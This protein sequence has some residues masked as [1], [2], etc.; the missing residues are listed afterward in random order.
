[1]NLLKN[2]LLITYLLPPHVS[3][4]KDQSFSRYHLVV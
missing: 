1:M 3:E 4:S 2:S